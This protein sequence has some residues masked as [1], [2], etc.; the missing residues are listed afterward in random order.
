MLTN[1]CLFRIYNS[2]AAEVAKNKLLAEIALERVGEREGLS[3]RAALQTLELISPES[4]ETGRI[5]RAWEE[6]YTGTKIVDV[7]EELWSE[8]DPRLVNLVRDRMKQA[9][10]RLSGKQTQEWLGRLEVKIETRSRRVPV[11][12]PGPKPGPTVVSPTQITIGAYAEGIKYSYEILTKTAEWLIGQ[13]KLTASGCPIS[14]G[15][16]RNIVNTKPSH[17]DGGDFRAPRQLSNG[18]WIETHHSTA[19]CV[20]YA[21]RLLKRF[22]YSEDMLEVE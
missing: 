20:G 18:L 14:S 13:G 21:R 7:V 16:R 6:A 15:R 11:V 19:G 2:L 22:G 4:I 9:G 5:G 1:G 12:K 8:P 10:Q 17:R 3:A